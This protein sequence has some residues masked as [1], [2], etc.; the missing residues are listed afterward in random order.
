M[1]HSRCQR[2]Q[3]SPNGQ[4]GTFFELE[5]R[6][7]VIVE[8]FVPPGAGK[9]TFAKALA[10]RLREAGRVV[11][12]HLSARPGEDVPASKSRG[13]AH[14]RP[15]PAD[16]FRRVARPLLQLIAAMVAGAELRD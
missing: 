2:S 12:L 16:P 4:S 8:L 11:D 5:G 6:T 14:S 9:T 3:G 10:A 7:S 1:R 13:E 15:S